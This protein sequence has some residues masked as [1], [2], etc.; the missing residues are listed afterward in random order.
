[1]K[2]LVIAASLAVGIAAISDG[3]TRTSEPVQHRYAASGGHWIIKADQNQATIYWNGNVW[4]YERSH[5]KVFSYHPSIYDL[6]FPGPS[7]MKDWDMSEKGWDV[8]FIYVVDCVNTDTKYYD[9][10]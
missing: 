3:Q 8:G 5:A 7:H 1:M 9:E 6:D 10:C 2:L 4:S